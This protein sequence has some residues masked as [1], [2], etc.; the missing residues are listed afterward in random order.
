M[1][2]ESRFTFKLTM[3]TLAIISK[4]AS[5]KSGS[6][7][8]FVQKSQWAYMSISSRSGARG[9]KRLSCFKYYNEMRWKS[10]FASVLHAAK[11][12]TYFKTCFK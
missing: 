4:N 2:W 3:S 9:L 1:K 10:K 5:N 8:N 11:I 6:A 12:T 7:F